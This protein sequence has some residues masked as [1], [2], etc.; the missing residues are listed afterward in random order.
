MMHG[1]GNPL[2][3]ACGMRGPSPYGKRG[4]VESEAVCDQAIANY[5]QKKRLFW[6]P[7]REGLSP[8]IV[9]GPVARGPR[10][11]PSA[12]A[13][14][15][16]AIGAW[17]GT[18]PRPTVTKAVPDTVARGPVPRAQM[19]LLCRA[20]SPDLDPFTLRRART[21]EGNNEIQFDKCRCP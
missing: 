1:E 8:A 6:I 20:R 10:R 2:A 16:P 15:F 19:L 4:R 3:C 9:L 14:G 18:G 17:R 12:H 21:T 7:S 5:K 11:F 13:S